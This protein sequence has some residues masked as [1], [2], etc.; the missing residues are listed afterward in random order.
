MTE[1]LEEL[2]E[3]ARKV[4]MTPVEKEDQRRS[5]AYGNT[6]IENE[7]ITRDMINDAADRIRPAKES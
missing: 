3:K 2:L 5:F 1:E 6:K 7:A 4:A